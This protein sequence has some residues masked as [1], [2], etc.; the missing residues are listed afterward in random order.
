MLKKMLIGAGAMLALLLLLVLALPTIVHSLGIH[1]VYEDARD[2]SLSG[3]RALLITTSHGV[4]NTPGETGGDPTGVMASEFTI[5]YYQFQ[6]AGMEVDISSIKG[7]E[8]PID[9][10]TLNRVLRSPEDER[11]LQDSVAQTK[12][13]NSLKIDDLDFTRYDV[14]WIAGGWGAAYDLG[15]SDVLGQKVSEA[16]YGDKETVFGS[17]CHGALGLIRA[18]DRD[19]KLLIAGRK[20]TGVSDKQIKELGIEVTPLHP[21]TELR[22]AGG[23]YSSQ[24]RFL[25]FFATS[26]VVDD[27]KRFVSGQNQ[28][29][30]HETAQNIMAI[31]DQRVK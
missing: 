13:N 5:A 19:G 24:Q 9:P 14:V 17:V 16:Y 2:Y 29:S 20:V 15:Y 6:D 3:K 21:E 4:L 28:N 23:I 22:K 31:L 12:A 11:F 1:P 8:I 10:Q 30:S 25:D 26:T 27:E 18:R 7:G